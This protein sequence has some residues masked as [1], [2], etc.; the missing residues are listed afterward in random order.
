SSIAVGSLF[1]ACSSSP[2][3]GTPPA[4]EPENVGAAA[5]PLRLRPNGFLPG[6]VLWR[7]PAV[8]I[9]ATPQCATTPSLTYFGGPILQ[10]PVIVPVFWN[11]SVNPQIKANIAQFYADVM[12]S[13]YWTWLEEYDTVGVSGGTNQAI[14]PGTSNAGLTIVPTKCTGTNNCAL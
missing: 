11:S 10:V 3:A 12:Q 7:D 6:E 2:D 13:T 1:V 9:E 4:T 14:L 5:Q 8:H